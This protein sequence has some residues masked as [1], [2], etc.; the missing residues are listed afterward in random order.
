MR[1]VIVSDTHGRHEELGILEGNVLIHCGDA[2]DGFKRDPRD[3]DRLD[4]W[5][6]RQQ[7]DEILCIGGNHDFAFEERA[8]IGARVLENA[9]FLI[10]AKFEYRGVRFYGSPWTPEL[11]GW[12]FYLDPEQ[13]KVR[14]SQIPADTDVLITHSPPAGILDANR[15]G[16]RCGC[17]H[18]AER[19]ETVRPS[20]HCFGH[21]HASAGRQLRAG[22][23][24]MNASMVN[25]QYQ[26]AHSPLIY[27]FRPDQ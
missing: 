1:L 22:T 18:L 4:R 13:A 12:A 19:V 21:V 9:V 16:R 5:F 23:L 27:D 15:S 25:S 6:G 7:F 24:Y 26:I 10:D 8:A 11:I 3:I 17:P 2:C 20:L 14:W